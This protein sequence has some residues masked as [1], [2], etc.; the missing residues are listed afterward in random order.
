MQYKD[1]EHFLLASSAFVFI[2]CCL[3][4]K[5]VPRWSETREESK[6]VTLM[7]RKVVI[8]DHLEIEIGIEHANDYNERMVLKR[9]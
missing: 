1:L 9:L 6:K 2:R 3:I 4:L 5:D 8:L 7:K